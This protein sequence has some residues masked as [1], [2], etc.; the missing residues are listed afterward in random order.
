PPGELT[1]AGRPPLRSLFQGPPFAQILRY[2]PDERLD[3]PVWITVRGKVR[4]DGTGS[5]R[6]GRVDVDDFAIGKQPLG[7]FLL[8]IFLGPSGGGVLKW[9]LPAVV[10][11]GEVGG[12]G[13][14]LTTRGRRGP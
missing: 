10:G 13:A 5:S 7:S 4:I 2:V 12:R 6:Y 1:G 9:P 8:S 3:Q 11:H 14:A